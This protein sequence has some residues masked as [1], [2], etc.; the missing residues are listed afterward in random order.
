MLSLAAFPPI[1]S[2]VR[3][4]FVTHETQ[5]NTGD[6]YRFAIEREQRMVGLADL[7]GVTGDEATLGYWLERQAWGQGFAFEAASAVVRFA[8]EDLGLR[9]IKAGHAADN[10]ASGRVLEKLGFRFVDAVSRSSRP[11]NGTIEQWR[12]ERER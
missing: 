11:R 12:Y 8:S 5:W 9:S 10:L 2:E 6:A 7:D 1:A 3:A 4:W